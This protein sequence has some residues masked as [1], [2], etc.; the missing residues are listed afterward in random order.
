L[1]RANIV[2]IKRIS[3]TINNNLVTQVEFVCRKKYT[4]IQNKNLSYN[5]KICQFKFQNLYTYQ[6]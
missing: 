3:F 6:N 5:V 1:K 4:Q 2:N